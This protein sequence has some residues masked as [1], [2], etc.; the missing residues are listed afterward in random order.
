VL[1]TDLKGMVSST[2]SSSALSALPTP[3]LLLNE[4]RLRANI[5]RMR[6]HLD[7][8]GVSFRPHLK[9]AKSLDVARLA[10]TSPSGPATVSTL[11][12]AEYFAEGGVR[13]ILYAVGI[14]ATKIDRV[15]AIRR[16]WAGW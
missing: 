11:R 7:R 13:D 12:E 10:M 9:T 15:G 3:C 5:A 4:V 16:R 14:E 1:T 2:E 6:R 8:L